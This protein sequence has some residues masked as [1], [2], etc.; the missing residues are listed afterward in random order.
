MVL[1]ENNL[2]AGFQC[3]SSNG[4]SP[5]NKC[6]IIESLHDT[7]IKARLSEIAALHVKSA[8]SHGNSIKIEKIG[9]LQKI[10]RRS[11]FR[12]SRGDVLLKRSGKVFHGEANY[13]FLYCFSSVS[14]CHRVR[15][16]VE[17]VGSFPERSETWCFDC[18]SWSWSGSLY[19]AWL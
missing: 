1:S 8:R 4:R 13:R 6:I 7:I 11:Q 19:F 5:I 2:F 9:L 15:T 17:A 10:L 18:W 14:S 16:A 3:D 12:D